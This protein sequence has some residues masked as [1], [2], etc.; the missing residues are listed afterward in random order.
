MSPALTTELA[1]TAWPYRLR[2]L[3][4]S[5]F[6]FA[7]IALSM[8]A[9]SLWVTQLAFT[10]AGPVIGAAWAVL[11]IAS[12]FHPENGTLSPRARLVG[13]LPSWLQTALRW[14][15]SVFLAFFVIFC[16]VVWPVFSL[17]NLWRLVQ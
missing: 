8:F 10:L 2:A 12:W 1:V 16:T 9:S 17:S 7:L 11:C 3:A 15:G 14:Y 13:S 6:V 4:L 5:V